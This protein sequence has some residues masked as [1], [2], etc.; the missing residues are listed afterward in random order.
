MR[1]FL[2]FALLGPLVGLAVMMVLTSYISDQ[3][4][5]PDARLLTY[6]LPLAYMMGIVPAVLAA[7]G[8]WWFAPRLGF[9]PR[10][11]ATCLA[12]YAVTVVA[13]LIIFSQSNN[14]LLDMMA[15]GFVGAIPA[16]ICSWLS[17]AR[18]P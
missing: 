11:G 9:W 1:R 13:G 5:I 15:F 16:A 14:S 10:I 2:I 8:D 17:N 7:L 6:G 3:V 18:T 12:G 4:I